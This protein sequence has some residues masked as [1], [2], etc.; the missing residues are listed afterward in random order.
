MALQKAIAEHPSVLDV[1]TS[2]DTANNNSV[3]S[4]KSAKGHENDDNLIWT[5][6]D[7]EMVNN[8]AILSEGD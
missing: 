8:S 7:A 2:S 1:S 6:T 4:Q 5:P 3:M